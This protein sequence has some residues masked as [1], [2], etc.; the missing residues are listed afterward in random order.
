MTSPP[1]DD[2]NGGLDWD[3]PGGNGNN[4]GADSDDGIQLKGASTALWK[5]TPCA[6]N[7]K[8]YYEDF[9]S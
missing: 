8:F 4:Q 6:G 3:Q 1:L 7:Y 9:L 2:H 5:Y